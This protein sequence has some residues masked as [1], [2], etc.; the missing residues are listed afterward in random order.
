VVPQ[1]ASTFRSGAVPV[2]ATRICHRKLGGGR[3]SSSPCS[4]PRMSTTSSSK[5]LT[6]PVRSGK[7]VTNQ[8]T[9]ASDGVSQRRWQPDSATSPDLPASD[10][11]RQRQRESPGMACKRPGVRVPLAPLVRDLLKSCKDQWTAK[12]TAKFMIAGR[13]S[14]SCAQRR[15]GERASARAGRRAR[16]CGCWNGRP[17]VRCPRSP[18]RRPTAC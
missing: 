7:P 1:P 16:S 3:A 2:T 9:T 4:P 6:L 13:R 5:G 14:G 17:G 12:L 10:P 11:G 8:V 15:S 18:R